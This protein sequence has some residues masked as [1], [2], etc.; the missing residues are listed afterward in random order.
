MNEKVIVEIPVVMRGS[1]GLGDSIYFKSK[2][3]T[4]LQLEAKLPCERKMRKVLQPYI[5]KKAIV[6]IIVEDGA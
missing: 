4:R 2:Y 1:M 5:G 6:R 3:D